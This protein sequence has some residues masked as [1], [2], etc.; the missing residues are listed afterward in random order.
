MS[1]PARHS[2]LRGQDRIAGSLSV[3]PFEGSRP[4]LAGQLLIGYSI[5]FVI[6]ELARRRDPCWLAES[7]TPFGTP[8]NS[9]LK[10]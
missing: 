3:E 1:D 2:S 5:G 8:E 7:A 6:P 9:A 10:Q 4:D